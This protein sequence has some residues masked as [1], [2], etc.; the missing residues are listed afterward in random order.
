VVLP[1]LRQ[2]AD[3][4]YGLVVL[5]DACL[6]GDPEVHRVLTEKVFRRHAQ[7]Q[8]FATFEFAGQVG[9]PGA[10]PRVHVNQTRPAFPA[11][12][13]QPLAK[14]GLGGLG[15]GAGASA[16]DARSAGVSSRRIRRGCDGG[17]YGGQ[18][19]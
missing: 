8:H 3:L 14:G 1:T 5:A 10:E 11:A 19:R 4:D 6:D 9:E 13:E 18:A 12:L 16:H 2:A 15:D 7:G 17:R